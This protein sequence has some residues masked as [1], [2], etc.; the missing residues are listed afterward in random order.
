VATPVRSIVFLLFTLAACAP[1]SP[2]PEKLQLF[3]VSFT[4]LPG[5][6]DDRQGDAL[7]ALRRSC[8][9]LPERGPALPH[10]VQTGPDAWP[11]MCKALAALQNPDH[12]A[13]RS[14]FE[15]WFTPFR[16]S[17]RDGATGLFTGYFEPQLRGALRPDKTYRF[18]LYG[19]PA[20]LVTVDLGKFRA[21]LKGERIAGKI[22]DGRLLP[23]ADRAAIT[24]GAL[25]NRGLELLWVD[26]AVDAFFLHIQGS[27]RVKLANGRE[28]RVGYAAGNGR[29]YRAIGRDLIERGEIPPDRMSMQAIRAWLAANPDQAQA[30]MARNRSFV[31]FRILP[32][33]GP[34]GALGVA[35]V[36]GRSLA[37]DRRFVPLGLPIWLDTTDPLSAAAK[38][39][40]RLMVA[41]DTGGAI[42]GPV[43]GDVFW[44]YGARAAARAGRMKARGQYFL[45][46]PRPVARPTS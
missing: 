41:Q 21:K 18:P 43:R 42:R 44:G 38:P 23:Y 35:L 36:P 46:L 7:P 8:K 25:G 45:L 24:R 31:F 27:G 34:I 33:D 13:A 32:G 14:F 1:T 11:A 37:V 9:A 19:R 4:A 26:S 28:V 30:L 29:A 17:G 10:P 6:S 20:D 22:A 16:A 39:L 40:R 5:W 3:P 2:T 15:R 12:R